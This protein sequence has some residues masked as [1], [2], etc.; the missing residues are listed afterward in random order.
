MGKRIFLAAIAAIILCGCT[1]KMPTVKNLKDL[2]FKVTGMK[3][4]NASVRSSSFS[5]NMDVYNTNREAVHMGR[6]EFKLYADGKKLIEGGTTEALD[7]APAETKPYALKAGIDHLGAGKMVVDFVAGKKLK[8]KTYELKAT[9]YLVT[10]V[11]EIA[12]SFTVP[13]ETIKKFL[14]KD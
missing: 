7:L 9:Y 5:M 6:F 1:I 13:D 14:C 4:E 12:I 3:V 11:G 10:S 2:D 8:E